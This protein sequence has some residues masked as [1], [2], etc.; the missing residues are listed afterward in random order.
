MPQLQPLLEVGGV[1]VIK[2]R[3]GLGAKELEDYIREFG[4]VP[5]TRSCPP[6]KDPKGGGEPSGRLM[7]AISGRNCTYKTFRFEQGPASRV[8]RCFASATCLIP[9]ISISAMCRYWRGA[10]SVQKWSR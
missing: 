6:K 3:E 1:M 9:R 2:G 5:L 10:S 4:E 8:V 7:I